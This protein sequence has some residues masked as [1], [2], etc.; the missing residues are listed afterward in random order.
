MKQI[1]LDLSEEAYKKL[2][3]IRRKEAPTQRNKTFC[4]DL[5]ESMITV[6]E[7][8]YKKKEKKNVRKR[9]QTRKRSK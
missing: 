7:E 4:R 9:P 3:E 6:F 5:L 1:K 8:D 2:D